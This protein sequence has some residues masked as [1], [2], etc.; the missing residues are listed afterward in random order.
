MSDN[1]VFV[2]AIAVF[3]VIFGIALMRVMKKA[4]IKYI[5][6]QYDMVRPVK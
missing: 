1:L 2:I 4:R 3:L 6:G 5:P